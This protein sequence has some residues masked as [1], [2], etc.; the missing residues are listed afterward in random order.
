VR[1]LD[2]CGAISESSADG[3]LDLGVSALPDCDTP[4]GA[5]PGNTHS[6][7]TAFYEL[8]R[9]GEMARGHWPSAEGGPASA[10]LH[11]QL[12]SVVNIAATCGAFWNGSSLNFYR[13]GGPCANTGQLAGAIDHEWGHGLDDN[14]TNGGIST[15]SEGI[16]DLYAAFRLGNSCIGRGFF[17]NGSLCTGYGDPC[18]PA[19]GCTGLREVDFA[20]RASG[21]PHTVAWVNGN[22]SCGS[23]H[24]RGALVS[25]AVWD[26]AQRDLPALFGMDDP[27]A[28]ELTSRLL[29]RGADN[30]GTWFV[31]GNGDQGGCAATGGYLQFLGVDDD[32]GTL[33]DGTPHMQAIFS[34]FD[35]HEIACATPAVGN[36]GCA[37]APSQAPVLTVT[38]G[39]TTATLSWTPVTDAVRYGI[40]RADGELPCSSG[41]IPVGTTTAASFE[42]TGLQNGRTYS[43]LVAPFGA[44]EACMGPA[45]ACIT[46]VPG[47]G[48]SMPFLADFEKGDLSEWSVTQ[49]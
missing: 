42:D 22:P 37:N 10:W 27:T 2:D 46:V 23:P 31:L 43:Y 13:E 19:S 9:I 35:R 11:A 40:Y 6:A 30:V 18:T 47:A 15:P 32:N 21:E 4:A 26:L 7:R 34:A 41:R 17:V 38:P 29:F 36:G 28:T 24:C 48:D 20:H 1:I 14:G 39:D 8:N 25:E 44:A 33:L 49:P 45:S 16:A 5:S 12:S 3:D